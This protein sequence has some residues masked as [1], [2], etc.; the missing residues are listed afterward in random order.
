MTTYRKALDTMQ[1]GLLS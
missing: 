1:V